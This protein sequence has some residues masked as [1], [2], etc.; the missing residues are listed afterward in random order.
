[1][2][3]QIMN[4]EMLVLL[5][6][7]QTGQQVIATGA[8]IKSEEGNRNEGNGDYIRWYEETWFIL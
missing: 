7:G 4:N 8:S 1:M 6:T 2:V 3:V 5:K